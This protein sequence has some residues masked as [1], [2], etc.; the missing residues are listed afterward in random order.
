MRAMLDWAFRVRGLAHAQW[1]TQPANERSSNVAKKLGMT[2]D[3]T[4]RQ[5]FPRPVGSGRGDLQIWSLLASEWL[6]PAVKAPGTKAQLD[7][8]TH[9]FLGA[10]TN[11]KGRRPNVGVI[12]ELFIPQGMIVKN[13]GA[14]PVVYDVEAFIEPRE[15]ILTDG[16]LTEF[17]EWEV[18]ERTEIFGSI[19]HRF[20]EYRKSGFLDGT[21][22]EGSG[23][24]TTQFVLTPSGWK[25][26]SMAWDDV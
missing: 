16:T 22:F 2:L 17:S 1:R 21:W 13:V 23:R 15:K 10:F 24:K 6:E 20:S 25:M 19:A 5:S 26:S 18:S 3:G 9:A 11:T 14:D 7:E 4:L 12:W 8:L